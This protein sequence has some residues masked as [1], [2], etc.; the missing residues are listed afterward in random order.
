MY[1]LMHLGWGR[2]EILG[3]TNQA[4]TLIDDNRVDVS[5]LQ[6]KTAASEVSNLKKFPHSH[7]KSDLM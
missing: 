2:W 3:L 6:T 1:I 5:V 4:V 7:E